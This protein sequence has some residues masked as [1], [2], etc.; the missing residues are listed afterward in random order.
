[1]RFNAI[2]ILFLILFLPFSCKSNS[3]ESAIPSAEVVQISE[4]DH[5]S[6]VTD[7]R[8]DSPS[9]QSSQAVRIFVPPVHNKS[10][11]VV[12]LLHGQTENEKMWSSLGFFRMAEKQMREGTIG[13][14]ILVTP[15]IDNSF[16]VNNE[17]TEKVQIPNGMQIE[18]NGNNYEDFLINDLIPYIDNKYK[19]IKDRSGRYIG[20]I[21]M[22]GFAAIHCAFRHPDQFSR[23]GG[24]SPA[25]ITDR[26]FSWLYPT[27]EIFENRNPMKLAERTDLSGFEILL[28]VG[29][30]D[31]YQLL[32]P[33]T[34]FYRLLEDRG[35]AVQLD[36]STGGHNSS[37]W[38]KQFPLYLRFYSEGLE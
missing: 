11:P 24:H 28:D 7:I 29:E 21:S 12:Y 2:P 1:M 26:D 20:G 14:M 5:G 6:Y 10:L 4:L 31:E 25:L 30:Q 13:P 17:K 8:L 15:D 19:T 3:S 34:S 16:G 9:L 36:T 37:Y 35:A 18:Y 38:K 27:E 32:E 33:V 23:I 22:G